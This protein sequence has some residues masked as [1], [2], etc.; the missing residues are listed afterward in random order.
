[1]QTLVPFETFIVRLVFLRFASVTSHFT[2]RFHSET[3]VTSA[4]ILCGAVA[5]ALLIGFAIG[6]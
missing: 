3:L 4:G 1:M 5:L 2:F 6:W